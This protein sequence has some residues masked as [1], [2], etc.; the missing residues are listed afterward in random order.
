MI[1]C[2]VFCLHAAA[3]YVVGCKHVVARHIVNH[4]ILSIKCFDDDS[5]V[6]LVGMNAA[7]IV[8][9]N[10]NRITAIFG[11]NQKIPRPGLV[12]IRRQFNL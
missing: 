7:D 9:R 3:D 11:I 1:L 6:I 2:V 10:T 8:V 4:H 12:Q 5:M